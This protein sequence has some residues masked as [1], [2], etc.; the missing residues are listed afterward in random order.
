MPCKQ[1][2]RGLA[3]KRLS[4]V[5]IMDTGALTLYVLANGIPWIDQFMLDQWLSVQSRAATYRL[6]VSCEL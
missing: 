4:P 1:A 3:W 5:L 6:A 2:S